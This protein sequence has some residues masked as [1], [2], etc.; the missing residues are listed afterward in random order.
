M[1]VNKVVWGNTTLIDLTSDTVTSASVLIGVSFH[2]PNGEV[3]TGTLQT[4]TYY[5]G[6]SAPASSLGVNGDI[7]LQTG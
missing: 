4:Q 1:A 5:T 7:Y 6:S 3:A 2:K